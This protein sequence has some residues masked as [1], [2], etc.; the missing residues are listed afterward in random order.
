M[1]IAE[2]YEEIYPNS[3]N[4]YRQLS[5]KAFTVSELHEAERIVTRELKYQFEPYPTPYGFLLRF[6][7]L[8]KLSEQELSFANLLLHICMYD[9]HMLRIKPSLQAVAV[10]IIS[11]K[12]TKGFSSQDDEDSQSSYNPE[13]VQMLLRQ[14]RLDFGKFSLLPALTDSV[15]AVQET[16]DKV[17]RAL[18]I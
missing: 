16:V 6:H 3:C 18:E 1:L 17:C 8:I 11:R 13:E 14:Q 2:K 12:V 4:T 7:A 10:I 15:D 9:Y 5:A